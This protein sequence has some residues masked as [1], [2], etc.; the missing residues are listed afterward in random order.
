MIHIGDHW[1]R[2]YDYVKY[3]LPF[4]IRTGIRY[5]DWHN[6]MEAIRER[7][8]EVNGFIPRKD[9][10]VYDVGA[11][12]GDYALIWAK[13]YDAQVI[14][15]EPLM[16]NNAEMLINML[17]NK[18]LK[19]RMVPSGLSDENQ[20]AVEVGYNGDMLDINNA[21]GKSATISLARL[22]TLVPLFNLEKPD[23]IKIDVEGYEMKVLKGA[24]NTIEEYYPKIIIETHSSDLKRQVQEFLEHMDY[25]LIYTGRT[26]TGMGWMDEVTNLFFL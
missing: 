25:D 20:S 4:R 26:T 10:V 13:V 7:M 6:C 15:F 1:G 14:T 3:Y 9:A 23:I 17:L 21:G 24:V 8:Y 19:I 22:D 5:Y 16:D 12:V 11:N 2:K 18:P